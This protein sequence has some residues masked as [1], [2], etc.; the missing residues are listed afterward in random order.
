MRDRRVEFAVSETRTHN[1][2]TKYAHKKKKELGK[3]EEENH[4]GLSPEDQK[5]SSRLQEL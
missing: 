5:N 4:K 2:Y 3:N 1:K